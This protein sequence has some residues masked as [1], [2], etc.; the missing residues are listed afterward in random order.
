MQADLHKTADREQAA[1]RSYLLQ[2]LSPALASN[3]FSEIDPVTE[4]VPWLTPQR[5]TGAWKPCLLALWSAAWKSSMKACS[6]CA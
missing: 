4:G 5:L 6:K 3:Y 2:R 1:Y